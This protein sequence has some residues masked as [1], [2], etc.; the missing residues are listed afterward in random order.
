MKMVEKMFILTSILCI[1]FQFVSSGICMKRE[2][3]MGDEC[4][5]DERQRPIMMG[6]QSESEHHLSKQE[7]KDMEKIGHELAKKGEYLNEEELLEKVHHKEKKY[8]KDSRDDQEDATEDEMTDQKQKEQKEMEK[9]LSKENY[10][11]KLLQ[12]GKQ[13]SKHLN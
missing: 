9:K 10:K 11:K 1:S 4:M 13:K 7:I 2:F 3:G 8:Y 5:E 12:Y 6:F